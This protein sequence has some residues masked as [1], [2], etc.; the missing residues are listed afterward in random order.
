ME[1][2]TSTF[3]TSQGEKIP[4]II[5]IGWEHIYIIYDRGEGRREQ[6]VKAITDEFGGFTW[7]LNKRSIKYQSPAQLLRTFTD[8]D[9]TASATFRHFTGI[10]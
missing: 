5:E 9:A 7:K 10:S 4:Y 6:E 8:F 1:I 2:F 3:T